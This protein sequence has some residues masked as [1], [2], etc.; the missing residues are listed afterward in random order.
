MYLSFD[1]TI[2]RTPSLN[3]ALV[4]SDFTMKE[5][6]PLLVEQ[7]DDFLRKSWSCTA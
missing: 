5:K 4:D 7:P 2:V 6:G 3:P 1:G